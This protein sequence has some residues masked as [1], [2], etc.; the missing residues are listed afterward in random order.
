MRM[1]YDAGGLGVVFEHYF[2]LGCDRGV[3]ST[4]SAADG[5]LRDTSLGDDELL[6]V[7]RAVCA[8]DG[9]WHSVLSAPY[10]NRAVSTGGSAPECGDLLASCPWSFGVA[11]LGRVYVVTPESRLVRVDTS[12]EYVRVLGRDALSSQ[13]L[14][15]SI[16]PSARFGTSHDSPA[17][18]T[19]I[20]MFFTPRGFEY[21]LGRIALDR[22]FADGT[23]P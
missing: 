18:L 2:D 7:G 14:G 6:I 19:G 5:L 23:E 10:G 20:S 4:S 9:N 16:L 15:L 3:S 11:L 8:N 12:I 1:T 22:L 13:E 21:G 17:Y